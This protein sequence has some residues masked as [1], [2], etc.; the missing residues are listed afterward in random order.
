MIEAASLRKF[1]ARL[2]ALESELRVTKEE[3]RVTKEELRG[4]K[5]ELRLSKIENAKLVSYIERQ[6]RYRDQLLPVV[7]ALLLSVER[8]HIATSSCSVSAMQR[9]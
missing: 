8:H 7:D 2:E 5:E 6:I 9:V 4:S 1:E 3:L